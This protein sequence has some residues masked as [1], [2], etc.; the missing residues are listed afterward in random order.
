MVDWG[1]Q[2]ATGNL[3]VIENTVGGCT[4]FPDS[5]TVDISGPSVDLGED[6]EICLGE[7]VT[8]VPEGNFTTHMWHD[9]STGPTYT[10]DT[11]ELVKIQVFDEAGC[12]EFDSVQV[13]AYPT[14]VVDLGNDTTL[15]G[16]MSL[17]LDAGNSGS[18]YR[19]ST[20]ETTQQI[21]VFAGEQLIWVVARNFA[22]CT[23]SASIRIRA[24]SP[25]DFFAH[26][27]NTITPNGDGRNDTW[28]ID[29]AA[30]YPDIEIEIFD[31]WGKLFWKSTRGYTVE[32]NGKNMSG[33][34][35]PMDSYYY[36][37][38]LHDG[39]DRITGT[40]TIMR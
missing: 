31:R 40:I 3:K 24:C 2:P 25:K 23:D 11:S 29:E 27:A 38:N 13:S 12:T 16:E 21:E 18:I 6:R 9:G 17:V 7:M 32:W 28:K 39:S 4:S 37:I 35:L 20:G 30:A 14:P 5:V 19:W 36:V 26:I 15:C 33:R 10:T 34:D 8:I 22:N 1:S